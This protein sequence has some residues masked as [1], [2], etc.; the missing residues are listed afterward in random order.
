[1]REPAIASLGGVELRASMI[2]YQIS[3][4]RVTPV[5]GKAHLL[6]YIQGSPMHKGG[7][8]GVSHRIVEDE[9]ESAVESR[10]EALSALRELGP[11][12]L[13]HLIK[14]SV[15]SGSRQ[16]RVPERRRL[17][18]PHDNLP[19]RLVSIIM[20]RELTRHPLPHWLHTSIHLFTPRWTRRKK[21]YLEYTGGFE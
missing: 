6:Q 12:D 8:D 17:L 3:A 11:P 18:R 13:V 1:M 2:P 16:V 10:N 19:I 20:L 9:I 7:T 14:Q 15:K 21:W 4:D 5:A